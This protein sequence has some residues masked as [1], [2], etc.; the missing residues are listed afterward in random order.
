MT[1]AHPIVRRMTRFR[2]ALLAPLAGCSLIYNPSNLPSPEI[3]AAVVVDTN[4]SLLEIR[5]ISPA[6]I[7]EGQGD[8][9][10]LPALFVIR[11]QNIVNANLKVQLVPPPG[12]TVLLEPITDAVA[13]QDTG[14][15]AFTVIARVDEAPPADVA[16]DVVVTQD[17]STQYGGGTVSRQLTGAVTLRGLPELTAMSSEVNQRELTVGASPPRYSRVDL[18]SVTPLTFKTGAAMPGVITAVSSIKLG[19]VN[20]N[21]SRTTPGPG[22]YAGAKSPGAGPGGGGLG[23]TVG[24]LGLGS[25][26]GGG[27]AGYAA[28]G[29]GGTKGAGLGGGAGGGGGDSVGDALLVSPTA[30]RASAGGAGGA[31]GLVSIV[32]GGAGGGGGGTVFLSAGGD[33]SATTIS[34][35]G[36]DGETPAG[37]GG[38]GGGGAGGTVLVASEAGT[39]TVGS[40]VVSGGRAGMPT[41]GGGS[42]GRARWDAP[43][44]NAPTSPDGPVQRGPAFAAQPRI[45]TQPTA[46]SLTGPA[47]VTFGVRVDSHDNVSQNG[48]GGTFNATGT[49]TITPSLR[50]GH[51]RVCMTLAGGTSGSFAEKCIDVALLP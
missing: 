1:P 33:I 48:N 35:T 3:D 45:V 2:A 19:A 24:G 40:I 37:G 26:G 34:A 8:G 23:A 21:A 6:V 31:G 46:L 50:P 41:G 44:G 22:G 43:A 10:S 39:V 16:L 4:E 42:I 28:A 29:T 38:G 49:A 32:D 36:G 7:E 12:V 27:G 51:N 11:G 13:S 17:V 14:Y 25:G 9:G 18:E 20:A 30:N 15:L 47:N 5:D